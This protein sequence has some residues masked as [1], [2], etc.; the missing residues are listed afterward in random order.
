MS[1]L[2]DVFLFYPPS[3]IF[4]LSL[5][6]YA[7]LMPAFF[8]GQRARHERVALKDQRLPSQD[9]R[10][11]P[12]VIS[13]VPTL[14]TAIQDSE[15]DEDMPLSPKPVQMVSKTSL[16]AQGEEDGSQK[17]GRKECEEDC[18]RVATLYCVQCEQYFCEICEVAMHRKG[19]YLRWR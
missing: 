13:A 16:P 8:L 15:S 7:H 10:P 11:N 12:S 4:P 14:N 5:S 3:C 17:A 2:P 18:G 1:V 19:M 6:S 9:M